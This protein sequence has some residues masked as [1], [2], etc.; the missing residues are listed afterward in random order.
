M[1][2]GRGGAANAADIDALIQSDPL[3][4]RPGMAIRR[5]A[6]LLIEAGA[7]AAPVTDDSGVLLGVLTQKDC[8]RPALQASYYQEWSGTVAD[9]MS[10]GAV[11]LPRGTDLFTAANAFLDHPHRAFPVTSGDRL[12]GMLH[13]SAVLRAL[14]E[15]G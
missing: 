2:A 1:S 12:A 7:T 15:L 9:V 5:A 11:T 4:L 6:A 8:F 13:R 10:Q 3:T 14:L